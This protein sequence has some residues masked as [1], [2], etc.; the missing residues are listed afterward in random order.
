MSEGIEKNKW[1]LK[2]LNINK[3]K[4]DKLFKFS[5]KLNNVLYNVKP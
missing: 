2:N 3:Q 5:E 1:V 4:I